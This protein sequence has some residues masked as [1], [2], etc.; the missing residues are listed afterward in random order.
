VPDLTD[1]RLAA[2]LASVADHLVVTPV[3]AATNGA[4]STPDPSAGPHDLQAAAD[5]R[6]A[7]VSAPHGPA[8]G[9]GRAPREAGDGDGPRISA[10]G[11]GE[12]GQPTDDAAAADAGTARPVGVGADAEA[13]PVAAGPHGVDPLAGT[14]EPAAETDEAAAGADGGEGIGRRRSGA[15][16]GG[17]RSGAGRR[18]RS[19]GSGGGRPGR[20]QPGARRPGV[21]SGVGPG[22]GPRPGRG[23]VLVAAVV[24][25][26][27]TIGSLVV[28]PVREAVAGW[29]G[30]GST[31][32][33]RVPVG[34]GDPGDLPYLGDDLDPV[35]E[36]EAEARLGVP[37]PDTDGTELGPAPVL[38]TPSEGGVVMAW[39]DGATTLWVQR[40][41]QPADQA[42]EKL[43]TM[44]DG[45]ERVDDLGDDAAVVEGP[46]I[47]LTPDRRLAAGTVVIWVDHDLEYRLESDLAVDEML[48]IAR[49]IGQG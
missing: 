36:R 23:R 39:S 19:S 46:H 15:A 48:E 42:V 8:V 4:E 13:P 32:I 47:L 40:T 9:T 28:A 29:L 24:L 21:G 41:A 20:R 6:D 1:E 37:L 12:P 22:V 18:R 45:F 34:E 10:P 7:D 25:V 30:I 38:A 26:V 5:D 33:E 31:E 49:S 3:P 14:H 2:V 35:T 17:R 11:D 27:A 43:L 44:D 16:Q